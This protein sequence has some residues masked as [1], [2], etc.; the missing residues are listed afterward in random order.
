VG[1]GQDAQAAEL[2]LKHL[3]V[4]LLRI[5]TYDRR[6]LARS[7]GKSAPILIVYHRN[8]QPS[9]TMHSDVA[10]TLEDL[11]PT[12]TVAGMRLEVASLGYNNVAELDARMAAIRPVAMF[13]C[14]GLNDAV[15]GLA[16]AARKRAVLTMTLNPA[17]V[18]SG[19]SIGLAPGDDRVNILVNLPASRAEGAE[20]DAA[21]LR[22]AEVYR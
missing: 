22:L 2:G 15:P 13:V 16:A 6:L 1:Q 19:L 20:L 10:N 9:E 14:S 8:D 4:L 7:G 12:V 17:Y 5:L 11:A 18:R 21:L 3:T